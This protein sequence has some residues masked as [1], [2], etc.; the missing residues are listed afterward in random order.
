[1]WNLFRKKQQIGAGKKVFVGVSGGVDSSV[2]LA[3]LRDAGYDVT[4][5]FIRT[6]HPDWLPCDWKEDRRDA[7]RV[8]AHVGVPFLELD[9]EGVYK[10]D[11]ADY[12]ISE[13]RAGRTPNPDVMCNRYVKFGAFWDWA[14]SRGADY[15]ATGHY[16]RIGNASEWK[17]ESGKLKVVSEAFAHSLQ[18]THYQLQTGIDPSKDQ[19][20]FLWTLRADE[21]AHIL[22]PIGHLPKSEVRKLAEQ[23]GL[24][25]A[26]KKDSQGICFLG[27]VDLREFLSRY[28]ETREGDVLDT[29]GR[30][31]GNHPGALFFTCGERHG[32]TITY[33][34]PNDQPYYVLLKDMDAN[35]IIV[36]QEPQRE[37]SASSFMLDSCVW[38]EFSDT[39]KYTAH[40][41]YHGIPKPCSIVRNG[42]TS[43]TVSFQESDYT[44]SPGQSIVIYD[45]DICIGGGIVE[46]AI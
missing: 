19:S 44:V 16:A 23:Y 9:L 30:I 43:A 15:I 7:M 4:G 40:I 45:G 18:A 1:M 27:H 39:K 28:I 41:R 46:K 37:Q 22:F 12:M 5:V 35:T 25:T 24:P 11:V 14:K 6:W 13:Y 38:R 21:L 17:V 42:D 31:I 8:C 20:Y 36:S 32:F 10:H 3:L 33:K 29:S 26:A 2:S 34:T